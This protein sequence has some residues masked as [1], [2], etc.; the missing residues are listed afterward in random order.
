[1][2]NARIAFARDASYLL[3]VLL[4]VLAFVP[5]FV[6]LAGFVP[7]RLGPHSLRLPMKSSLET[8]LVF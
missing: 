7:D 8:R 5:A 1:M 6:G 2:A 3:L 4:R